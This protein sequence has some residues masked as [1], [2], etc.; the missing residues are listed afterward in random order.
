MIAEVA[1]A[2]HLL[3]YKQHD[4][5]QFAKAGMLDKAILF[6]QDEQEAFCNVY[7]FQDGRHSDAGLHGPPVSCVIVRGVATSKGG[8]GGGGFSSEC[9]YM[10]CVVYI[11]LRGCGL[12]RLKD[13]VSLRPSCVQ[14]GPRAK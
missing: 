14:P 6:N 9:A 13:D 8:G 7:S 10:I 1:W 5:S 3:P 12:P 4:L 11:S 2:T